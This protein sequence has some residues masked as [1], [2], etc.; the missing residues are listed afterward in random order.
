MCIEEW[1]GG[2]GGEGGRGNGSFV[3]VRAPSF[4][5]LK[6]YGAPLMCYLLEILFSWLTVVKSQQSYKKLSGF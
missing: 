5:G 6:F 1:G 4:W 3:P 2:G